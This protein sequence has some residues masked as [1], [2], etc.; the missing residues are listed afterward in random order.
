[1]RCGVAEEKSCGSIENGLGVFC[2]GPG[3]RRVHGDRQSFPKEERTKSDKAKSPTLKR[4]REVGGLPFTAK[5]DWP[6]KNRRARSLSNR[7]DQ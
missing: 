1:M 6:K 3:G 5:K 7:W 4:G 2:T